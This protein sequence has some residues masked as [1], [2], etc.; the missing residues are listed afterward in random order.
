MSELNRAVIDLD[1]MKTQAEATNKEYDRLMDEHAKLQVTAL[2]VQC[3]SL[4]VASLHERFSA[5]SDFV[6]QIPH[7]H[8]NIK[9]GSARCRA[10]PLRPTK[11]SCGPGPP[12]GGGL[13]PDR[14][15]SAHID[16]AR[17]GRFGV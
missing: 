17:P 6:N 2:L 1:V 16:G 13:G 10:R 11:M 14:R 9:L 3:N 5:H 15:G 4:S 12:R 8:Y 7:L